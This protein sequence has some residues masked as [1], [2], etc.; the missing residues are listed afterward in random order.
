MEKTK[1]HYNKKN[2]QESNKKQRGTKLKFKTIID[3]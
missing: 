1:E 3:K 2:K